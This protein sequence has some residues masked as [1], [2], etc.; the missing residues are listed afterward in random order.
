MSTQTKKVYQVLNA[1]AEGLGLFRAADAK[2][3]V[4]LSKSAIGIMLH[5]R[6]HSPTSAVPFTATV[7]RADRWNAYVSPIGGRE[8]DV[9]CVGFCMSQGEA[10]RLVFSIASTGQV[11]HGLDGEVAA[12]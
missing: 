1:R 8:E 4:A 11:Q 6:E 9:V 2:A 7:A 10:S 12:V 5:G 3:A